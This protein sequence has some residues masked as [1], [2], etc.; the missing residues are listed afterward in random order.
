[1]NTSLKVEVQVF[2]FIAKEL[3]MVHYD[4]NFFGEETRRSP[5]FPVFGRL[6]GCVDHKNCG[7]CRDGSPGGVGLVA[8]ALRTPPFGWQLALDAQLQDLREGH[9]R[10]LLVPYRRL[11]WREA[12][13]DR[14]LVLLEVSIFCEHSHLPPLDR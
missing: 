9:F 6:D 1:M 12:E 11:L 5:E 7:H 10:C 3:A 2:S 4:T 13:Q 8:L 14:F